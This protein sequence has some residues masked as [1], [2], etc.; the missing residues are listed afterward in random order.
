MS[1]E[2]MDKITDNCESDLD[3]RFYETR[4]GDTLFGIARQQLGQASR[5]VDLMKLNEFRLESNMTH[6]T[7][8]SPGIKLL[9]PIK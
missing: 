5:Y 6:E 2:M 8:L 4:A 1:D 7:E 3:K 9:L